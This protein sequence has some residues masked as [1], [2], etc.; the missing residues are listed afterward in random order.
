MINSDIKSFNENP[1]D[2]QF[3]LTKKEN[4]FYVHVLGYH[5]LKYVNAIPAKRTQNCH[6]LHFVLSG[7]GTIVVNG[8]KYQA[9]PFDV[10][11]VDDKS[12]FSYYPDPQNPWEYVFFEVNGTLVEKLIKTTVSLR[13]LN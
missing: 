9:K 7:A 8:N 3:F 6:T 4:E 13:L 5:N 2:F 1:E 11:Y 10:F 12:L